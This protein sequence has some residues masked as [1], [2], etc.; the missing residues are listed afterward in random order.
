MPT[1]EPKPDHTP[2]AKEHNL[3]LRMLRVYCGHHHGT[4]QD[5]LCPDCTALAAYAEQRLMRCPY[6]GKKPTCRNCPIHCYRPAEREQVKAVMR[7]AGPRLVKSGDFGAL[8]H[9]VHGLKKPPDR[10]CKK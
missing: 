5:E 4:Q 7:F 8:M 6:G 2:R 10:P 3:F 1:P 9:L